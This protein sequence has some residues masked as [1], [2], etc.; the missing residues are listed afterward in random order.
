MVPSV[1]PLSKASS[2]SALATTVYVFPVST[3]TLV[4]TPGNHLSTLGFAVLG[5]I[6]VR[7]YWTPFSLTPESASCLVRVTVQWILLLGRS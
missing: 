5:S 6:L 1:L 7:V 2:F 3:V 4:C